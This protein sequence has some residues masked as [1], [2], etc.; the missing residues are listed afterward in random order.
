MEL[1]YTG[2]LILCGVCVVCVGVVVCGVCVVCVWCVWGWW[3]VCALQIAMTNEQT[4]CT[5]Q[6][7]VT[8]KYLNNNGMQYHNLVYLE[9]VKE[10][11]WNE[12]DMFS[13]IT[14]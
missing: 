14:I 9:T 6:V 11:P 5:V 3:C 13:L 1:F 2:R 7:Y 4:A 10:Q 12:V 8:R